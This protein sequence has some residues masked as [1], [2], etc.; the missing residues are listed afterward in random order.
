MAEYFAHGLAV[1]TT[2]YGF[3]G[4]PAEPGQHCLVA[5]NGSFADALVSLAEGGREEMERLGRE[6]RRLVVEWLNWETISEALF[7]EF[8]ELVE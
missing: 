2:E 5:E 8:R 1:V 4:V 3:R 6:S 7:G